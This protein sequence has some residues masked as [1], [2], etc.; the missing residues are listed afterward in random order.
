MATVAQAAVA[1]IL[2]FLQAAK[3]AVRETDLGCHGFS[4]ICP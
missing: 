3:I 2:F 1:M 4:T